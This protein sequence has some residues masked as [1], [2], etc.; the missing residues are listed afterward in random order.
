MID[1]YPNI[2]WH[3]PK[4][5]FGH[6]LAVPLGEPNTWPKSRT[7]KS[8]PECC[9]IVRDINKLPDVLDISKIV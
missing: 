1:V 3:F 9:F 6:I 4:L 2:K 5:K 8:V 7:G